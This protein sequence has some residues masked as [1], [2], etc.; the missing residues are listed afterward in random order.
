M[1]GNMDKPL[2]AAE[3]ECRADL[4]HRVVSL[5]FW[6]KDKRLVDVWLAGP[7]IF[8]LRAEIEKMLRANPE[9]L[10]W[11]ASFRAN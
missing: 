11:Q 7:D 3:L 1:I 6:D 4:D 8:F 2:K 5:R 9:M 10:T